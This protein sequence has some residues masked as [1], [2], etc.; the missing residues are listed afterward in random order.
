MALAQL[1]KATKAPN[2]Y[3][4]RGKSMNFL[5]SSWHPIWPLSDKKTYSKHTLKDAKVN[6][7]I[8]QSSY[9]LYFTYLEDKTI[10]IELFA[11]PILYFWRQLPK[12]RPIHPYFE[13]FSFDDNWKTKSKYSLKKTFH[14]KT[15]ITFMYI[16][17][18]R[19]AGGK[20]ENIRRTVNKK[21]SWNNLR[22]KKESFRDCA[23]NNFLSCFPGWFSR[24][25]HSV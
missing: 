1:N 10:T 16:I 23:E 25:T 14:S 15:S 6:G 19:S 21:T 12:N 8:I 4:S 18:G 7:F 17:W 5:T 13:Q 11:E 3:F 22:W 2:I 20:A 24:E 9:I